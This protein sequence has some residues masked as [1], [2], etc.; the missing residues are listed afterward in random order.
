M[1]KSKA[2]VGDV[3]RAG[4]WPRLMGHL[5]A[6]RTPSA[7]RVIQLAAD[8]PTRLDIIQQTAARLIQLGKQAREFADAWFDDRPTSF[9]NPVQLQMDCYPNVEGGDPGDYN[10][11]FVVK[12]KSGRELPVRFSTD[13]LIDANDARQ[14][15]WDSLQ[16]H[17]S[18]TPGV[19]DFLTPTRYNQATIVP[20]SVW[21]C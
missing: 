10:Y 20:I 1:A 9:T 17:S 13:D 6:A 7:R 4:F 5:S 12:F 11:E 2:S 18:D 16:E 15:I 8:Y 14:V 21:R 19:T 3:L